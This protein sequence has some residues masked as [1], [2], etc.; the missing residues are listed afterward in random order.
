MRWGLV[1]ASTIA[2]EWMIDAIR[3]N[4]GE[5]IGVQS[6]SEAHGAEYAQKHGIAYSTTEVDALLD[7]QPDAIYISSV[8]DKHRAQL[9]AAANRGIHVLC[10][11]PLATSLDDAKAMIEVCDANSVRFATN[12]HLRWAA[13]HQAIRA[14]IAAGHIGEVRSARVFHAV[15][16]P[17]HLQ[18]WRIDNPAA[19]GGVVLDITVHNCDILAYL[20]GEYPQEVVSM[21]DHKLFGDLVEDEAMSVWRYPSGVLAYTHESF[22]T[23]HAG[24]GIEIHGSEGSLIGDSVMSQQPVG[25]V[26]LQRNGERQELSVDPHNLYQ[27]GVADFVAA[28]KEGRAPACDGVAGTRSLAVALAVLESAKSGTKVSVDYAGV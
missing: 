19:G 3:A 2:A 15:Y 14:A 6:G 25:K 7:Q 10:E 21:T 24:H 28:V 23:P 12:H 22:A 9:E 27:A 5:I 13:T 17:P 18:G 26:Y 20:L 16:L 11:K 1:G 4:G 8:N